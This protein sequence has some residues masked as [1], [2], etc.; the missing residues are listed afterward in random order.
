MAISNAPEAETPL[1]P[2]GVVSGSVDYKRRPSVRSRSGCWKS[3]SFIIGVEVAER[4]AYYGISSNL[5]SYF[6]GP[7]GQSTAAA[8]ANVNAWSGM[9]TLL[10]LAGAFV[11]DSVL[12]RYRTIIAASL[13]YVLQ[14][15]THLQG[16][17]LL[18]L[19]AAFHTFNSS[20]CKNDANNNNM[21]CSPPSLEVIIFFLSLYL[22]ALAQSGHKPCV[23]AFG[24]DQFDEDDVNELKSKSSFF[25][26]WYF[27]MNGGILVAILVLSYV[28]DNLS[29]ELG[30]G[31]PCIAMC[32]A[33][34]IFLLGT[35]TYRF[36]VNSTGK[37]PFVRIGWVFVK[38]ARNRRFEPEIK[39]IE[40][41]ARESTKF[42]FLDK[43][44]LLPNTPDEQEHTVTLADI[45]DAKTILQ[46]VPIWSA[47][48]GFA[49]IFSQ[50]STLF[51][52]QGA[53]MDRHIITGTTFQIPAASLQSLIS[54]SIM[55][56]VP[57][58]DRILV[59]TA[60]SLTKNPSGITM[61]QRIGT[62]VFLSFTTMV[63]AALV[64]HKRLTTAVEHGLV[65]KPEST[66]PM[67]VLWLAPQYLLFGLAEVFTMVGLQEFFYDQVPVDLKSIGLSLYLSIFGT[68]GFLSSFLISVIEK[69]TGG[70][71]DFGW[72]ANNL[73]RGHLDY[74]YWLLSGL[75]ALTM[76]GFVYFSRCYVYRRKRCSALFV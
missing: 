4:F 39:S 14:A 36:R 8:A 66:V 56:F 33:L 32:F 35:P 1:L 44:I 49:V 76:V 30:F 21:S 71:G 12:G 24:A 72:F 5:I 70:H 64:E 54:I 11:A 27:S 29:W 13:L 60:Q 74:F 73:N 31:I 7:L 59:P 9:A 51:T 40:E 52:K 47:C 45:D 15:H 58:Y 43:A 46:L 2:D 63:T 19:S 6:T 62:G 23:Q 48:L 20:N 65:D 34:C 22:I 26:W 69:V 53:T 38:A 42:K 75:S 37:N 16:L 50:V 57:I 67:S 3:A 18:S 41:E 28:Q 17:G 68:G 10:P 61:L 25:N 55:L